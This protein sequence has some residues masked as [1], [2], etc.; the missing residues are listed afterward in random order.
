M[1]HAWYVVQ[2]G[3]KA[4]RNDEVTKGGMTADHGHH[5]CEAAKCVKK[6]VEKYVGRMDLQ[7]AVNAAL[8]LPT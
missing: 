6:R 8:E 1:I 3:K 2:C 4:K 7:A 5:F